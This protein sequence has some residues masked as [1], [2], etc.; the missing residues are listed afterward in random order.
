MADDFEKLFARKIFKIIGEQKPGDIAELRRMAGLAR[1]RGL[2]RLADHAEQ[3]ALL[4]E[5]EDLRRARRG[6][7]TRE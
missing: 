2:T 6:E 4:F 1:F 5:E 7:P 3:I